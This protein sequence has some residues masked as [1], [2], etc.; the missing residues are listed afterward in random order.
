MTVWCLGPIIPVDIP[1]EDDTL[2]SDDGVASL[3]EEEVL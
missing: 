3:S 1:E 2:E